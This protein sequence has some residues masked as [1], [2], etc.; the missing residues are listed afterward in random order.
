MKIA[1]QTIQNH[2]PC[3]KP[4][5]TILFTKLSHPIMRY[6]IVL[7]FVAIVVLL[8]SC[9]V[10]RQGEVGVKRTLGKYSDKSYTEGLKVFNPFTSR[11]IK[12]LT[13]TENMEVELGIPSKEGLNIRSEVSIL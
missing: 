13:Q 5:T 2:N 6:N 10:V 3:S 1:V 4:V 12:V 11:V 7:V 9:V 8:S